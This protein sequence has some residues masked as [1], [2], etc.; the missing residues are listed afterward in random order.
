M[1]TENSLFFY[2]LVALDLLVVACVHVDPGKIKQ[3]RVSENA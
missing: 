2:P 3:Q 1:L